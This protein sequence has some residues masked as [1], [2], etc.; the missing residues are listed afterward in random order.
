MNPQPDP[1]IGH[2]FAAM[3][4]IAIV[5]YAVKAAK[6]NKV[7]RFDD[8]FVI[9]YVES[10]PIVINEVHHNHK[11]VKTI[12]K[13]TKTRTKIKKV[14]DV[15]SQQLY[16]DC[17]DALVALGMKKRQAQNQA[18]F[19]FSTTHPRPKTIQEFLMIALKLP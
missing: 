14:V 18:T 4:I 10:S 13:K 15:E 2:I 9:G 8:N 19:V 11:T 6:E 1:I 3:F 5:F 16:A 7:V 17:V 12:E